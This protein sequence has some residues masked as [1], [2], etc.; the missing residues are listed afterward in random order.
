M[1]YDLENE[2]WSNISILLNLIYTFNAIP[3]KSHIFVEVGM[4]ISKIH[5]DL[6]MT[7]NSQ[8]IF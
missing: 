3:I 6:P 1:S 4:L 2:I 7:K 5:M 8:N